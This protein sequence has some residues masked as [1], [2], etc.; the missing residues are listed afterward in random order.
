MNTDRSTSRVRRQFVRLVCALLVLVL[1]AFSQ[2]VSL[3]LGG[4]PKASAHAFTLPTCSMPCS[5]VWSGYEV[6]ADTFDDIKGE[7]NVQTATYPN[8]YSMLAT[9]VGVGGENGNQYLA[10]T[11][12]A[13]SNGA[14]HP[15]YEF[16]PNPPVI[17]V[18]TNLAA[19]THVV[20]EVYKS[21]ANWCTS[22]TW[23]SGSMYTCSV[24]GFAADQST[25][26]WIDE[27]PCGGYMLL[28]FGVTNF[29]GGYAHSITR[30]WHTI[31]GFPRYKRY[32]I[33]TST[34]ATLAT[35]GD[36]LTGTTAFPDN[37]QKSGTLSA[38]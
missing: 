20:A 13:W 7:W 17:G 18:N 32:M 9:W 35:P 6:Y 19:G 38:C 14:F 12:T 25:A 10:Q 11:G 36:L 27:R 15:F 3:H 30:G 2:L 1:V 28:N 37:Y 5:Y 21:G 26:E 22:V 29:S 16:Y 8:S 33:D 23:P 4:A 31:G 34:G 24:G